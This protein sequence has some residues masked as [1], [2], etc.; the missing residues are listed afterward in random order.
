MSRYLLVLCILLLLLVVG[1]TIDIEIDFN[2]DSTDGVRA[3]LCT[4]ARTEG[5]TSIPGITR[6]RGNVLKILHTSDNVAF[7]VSVH[8]TR[9]R[10]NHGT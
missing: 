10:N 7:S 5:A 8:V 6:L 4:G 1:S 3:F 9:Q 2:I